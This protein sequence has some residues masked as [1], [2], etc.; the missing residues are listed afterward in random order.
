M[1]GRSDGA[2]TPERVLIRLPNPIG[3]SV[4]ST[5]ALAALR[6]HWPEA[7][8]VA[9]G[10]GSATALLAGL[11]SVDELR[12][13]P[14]RRAPG[15]PRALAAA[16]AAL[17]A[18]RFD[19][20]LLMANSFS[21]AWMV[22]RTGAARRVGYGGGG[23]ALLLTDVVP[24]AP[25]PP[26]HRM[27]QPMVEFYFR[28]VEHVGAP[29]GS[30][31]TQLVVTDADEERGQA[32]LA[33]HGLLDGA[34]LY[35]MHGGASFGPSK[36]WYPERWAAVADTLHAR[37]GGR[38]ILFCGPGEEAD[39][40]AIAAAARSPVASAAEDP[41]DLRTLKAVMRR[42]SLLIATDAG[43]RH[44]GVAFDVPC[45]ALL[46]PT[47]PRFSSTNLQHSV[48]VRTGVACSPCHRKVCPL[49]EPAHHCCMREISPEMVLAAAERL[50]AHTA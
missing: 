5:P 39:V 29:R 19:L 28:L 48:L 43:P 37:H 45:V 3:D 30:H 20:A 40:R 22:W 21:S 33:R 50:L 27:P 16:A 14:S 11:P 42:L 25:E 34:P 31:R 15:G 17:R 8:L 18:E 47:D 13:I 12:T 46:G 7:R 4:M 36:L 49:P 35:G 41:I 23:R 44:V 26:F 6:A 10:P 24:S 32:W 1:A 9:A 2:S 38:T